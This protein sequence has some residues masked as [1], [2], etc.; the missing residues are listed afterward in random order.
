MNPALLKITET[1][2]DIII[3]WGEV[4]SEEWKFSPTERLLLERLK[5]W[6]EERARYIGIT[7]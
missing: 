1:E 5:R 6:K 3:R 7:D 2:L 4:V